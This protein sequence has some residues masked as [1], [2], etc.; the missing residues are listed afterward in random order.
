[1]RCFSNRRNRKSPS[2]LRFPPF[3]CF[4]SSFLSFLPSCKGI[5]FDRAF[6]TNSICGPSRA[7]T[8][9]G[10]Y[11]H[12][13]GFYAN[14]FD[15]TFDEEQWTFPKALHDHGYWTGIVGKYH[16]GTQSLDGSFDY[17]NVLI[18]QVRC[19]ASAGREG[20]GKRGREGEIKLQP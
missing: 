5:R 20:A 18:D 3:L 14:L 6:V 2:L 1:M 15:F 7:T 17:S 10:K 9:T 12:K 4:Y 8:L 11:S 19:G 13:N 16:L